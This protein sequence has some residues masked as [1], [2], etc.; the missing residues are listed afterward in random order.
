M[1]LAGPIPSNSSLGKQAL[2]LVKLQRTNLPALHVQPVQQCALLFDEAMRVCS[3]AE[4]D[5]NRAEVVLAEGQD[6]RGNSLVGA[7]P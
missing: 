6:Q 1:R 7:S 4:Q 3:L 2:K 5:F